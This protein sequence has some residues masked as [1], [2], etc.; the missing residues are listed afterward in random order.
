MPEG[1]SLLQ[2]NYYCTVLHCTSIDEY[3]VPDFWAFVPLYYPYVILVRVVSNSKSVS[4]MSDP[5]TLILRSFV[6]YAN[7]C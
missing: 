4:A 1:V 5:Y 6:R 3:L 7:V 2:D